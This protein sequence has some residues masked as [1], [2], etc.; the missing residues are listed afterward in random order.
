MTT[1]YDVRVWK[2]Q[3]RYKKG[4]NGKR[5][6]TRYVVRWMVGSER[7]D[8]TYK[9]RA[10]ADSF[11]ADLLSASRKGEAFD[12]AEGLPLSMLREID[13]KSWYDFAVMYADMKWDAS[14]PKHRSS[15]ADSLIAIT[16][17]MLRDAA[18]RPENKVISLALRRAF[19]RNRRDD[20]CPDELAA[21]LAW[22]VRNV[23]PVGDL[24][25]PTVFRHVMTQLDKKR[26]GER[27]AHDTIRLR[28]TI[29]RNALDY[30]TEKNLLDT[31]PVNEVKVKKHG[32]VIRQV[33]KRS[34]ANPV[35]LRTLL[36]SVRE[37]DARLV[38]FFG[39][40]GFAALRPEEAVNL[41]KRNLS[42]PQKGWGEIHLERATPEIGEEWTDTRT[43]N[44]ERNLKHREDAVGRTVPCSDELTGLLH[45][46]IDQHGTTPDGRL[47]RGAR[48]G[49]LGSTVY[50][51]AWAKARASAFVPE[52]VD[53]PLAKRPY[54]LRHAAVSAWL[55]ATGDPTRVAEWAGHSVSVLLRI[56]AKCLDAGE[57]DARNK[58]ARWLKG[59]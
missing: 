30:A 38:A 9:N 57:Q 42:L 26:D 46:H 11:R 49:P 22:T 54:D 12:L 2:L 7:F 47:F 35:Q 39:L 18:G 43:R 10:Q 41:R 36:N 40:M 51:R 19:N 17:G 29:L 15:I 1:S 27:A 6:P 25:D 24:A 16:L 14:S 21:A 32:A 23:R 8:K 33:D 53:S 58:V 52:V 37:I 4:K 3:T 5:V 55:N 48:G 13:E 44:E 45:E 59:E 31:N 34:V 56:Y 50:G 28:R 20:D